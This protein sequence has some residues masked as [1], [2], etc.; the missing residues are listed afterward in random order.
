MNFFEQ[1]VQ[2]EQK[3]KNIRGYATAQSNLDQLQS[4]VQ[5]RKT[6]EMY[7]PKAAFD[8]MMNR[9]ETVDLLKRLSIR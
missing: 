1:L 8:L 7:D 6:G 9:P 5:D 4:M 3:A 2:M